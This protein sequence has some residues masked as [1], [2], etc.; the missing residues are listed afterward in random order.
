[1]R[2]SLCPVQFR[3]QDEYLRLPAKDCGLQNP[4]GHPLYRYG[5]LR[6][7]EHLFLFLVYF[8]MLASRLLLGTI[9]RGTRQ[10]H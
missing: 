2:T 9:H 3:R 8:P 5:R 7:H 1:M 10:M 6:D 4:T